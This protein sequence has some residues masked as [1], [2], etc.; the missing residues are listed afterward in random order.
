M[1]ALDEAPED[2]APEDEPP[3][4]APALPEAEPEAE[5]V[6]VGVAAEE[7]ELAGGVDGELVVAVGED[8]LEADFESSLPHAASATAAAAAIRS[9]FFMDC[10][11]TLSGTPSRGAGEF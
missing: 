9:A 4:V 11:L 2:G 5:P 6:V 3:G 7:D 10:P 8:D 1:L